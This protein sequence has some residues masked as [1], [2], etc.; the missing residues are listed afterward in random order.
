MANF[1]VTHAFIQYLYCIYMYI[2]ILQYILSTYSMVFLTQNDATLSRN[3]INVLFMSKD[4]SNL[5]DVESFEV[6]DE[7]EA[8]D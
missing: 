6:R 1:P 7:G 2:I 3:A 8:L 4:L 5:S